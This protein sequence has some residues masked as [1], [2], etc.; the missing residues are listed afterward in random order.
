MPYYYVQEELDEK[1]RQARA[2]MILCF[3]IL[4]VNAVG[5]LGG[6]ST[7]DLAQSLFRAR[8][9]QPPCVA[10]RGPHAAALTRRRR[11]RSQTSRRTAS[12][13]SC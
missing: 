10:R 1:M 13:A 9:A 4:F 8:R 2:A 12:A 5:F 3:C 7:F 11:A 6:F